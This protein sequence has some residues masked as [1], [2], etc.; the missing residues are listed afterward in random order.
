[1]TILTFLNSQNPFVASFYMNFETFYY[2]FGGCYYVDSD[3]NN[4]S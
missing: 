2:V 4:F 1:M 3:N